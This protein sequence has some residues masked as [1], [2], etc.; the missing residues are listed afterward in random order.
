[1]PCPPILAPLRAG[2]P[3]AALLSL[4]ASCAEARRA[5]AE[6]RYHAPSV[7]VAYPGRDTA[8]PADKPFV[9]FRFAPGE[10]DDPVDVSSFRATVD[11]VD[12]TARFHVTASQAWAA[13][14]DSA[15]SPPGAAMLPVGSHTVNAR[16]CSARGAC[17]AVAL[18]VDVRS[19]ERA[20]GARPDP[21]TPARPTDNTSTASRTAA[22][23]RH[24]GARGAG[25]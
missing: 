10:P 5:R 6:W 16:I 21:R 3:L 14:G 19:W 8:L 20:I 17:G 7:V 9:V 22:A 15:A 2:A 11:G 1:M 25:V 24:G 4:A 18:V 12:R 13:L 23:V